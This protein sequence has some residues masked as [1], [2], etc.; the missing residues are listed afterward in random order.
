[1][2]KKSFLK[3]TECCDYPHIG[4]N[5]YVSFIYIYIYIYIYIFMYVYMYMYICIYICII[6]V[7]HIYIAHSA[8]LM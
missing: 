6:Y 7:Y 4:N 3:K 2:L 1:M 8:T 5:M